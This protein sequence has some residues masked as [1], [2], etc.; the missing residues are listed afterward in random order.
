MVMVLMIMIVV[1]V[2]VM[3]GTITMMRVVMR[4][5][6][7]GMIVR[8]RMGV[9]VGMR[10]ARPVGMRVPM[11]MAWFGN[12]TRAGIH[13]NGNVRLRDQT[14]GFHR[15]RLHRLDPESLDLSTATFRAHDSPLAEF[16]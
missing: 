2:M 10:M 7:V 5:M 1:M 13:R 16:G 12:D 11:G 3:V 4:T 8:V 6:P 15:R 9:M 14:H